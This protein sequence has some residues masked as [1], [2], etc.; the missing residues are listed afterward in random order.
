MDYTATVSHLYYAAA[1]VT[2]FVQDTFGQKWIKQ[3][4]PG[5]LVN[6]SFKVS[7]ILTHWN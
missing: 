1:Q 5:H 3:T 2:G 4:Q 6:G 7:H